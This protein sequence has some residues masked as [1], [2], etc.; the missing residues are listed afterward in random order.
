MAKPKV[1]QGVDWFLPGRK[2]RFA[3]TTPASAFLIEVLA[4]DG[5]TWSQI[6][7]Q[8]LYDPDAKAV[9]EHF[10][11]AGYD[12]TPAHTMLAGAR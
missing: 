5:L 12:Q 7:Q 4:E 1:S 9:A 2:R 3:T 6:A 11:A 8:V 10:T